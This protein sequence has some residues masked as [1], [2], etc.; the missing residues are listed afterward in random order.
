MAQ[1]YVLNLDVRFIIENESEII[2]QKI[3][4]MSLDSQSI[5]L[6]GGACIEIINFLMTPRTYSEIQGK[7]KT[8]IKN[9]DDI[10]ISLIK[11]GILSLR[12]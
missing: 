12:S 1:F 7:F 11:N 2:V 5:L 6:R 10:L 3:S 4:S 9:V 8:Q